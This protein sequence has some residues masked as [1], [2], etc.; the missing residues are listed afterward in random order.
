MVNILWRS[1]LRFD[2]AV[3]VSVGRRLEKRRIFDMHEAIQEKH[4]KEFSRHAHVSLVL[5]SRSSK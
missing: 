4:S 1:Q 5:L 2:E 3:I